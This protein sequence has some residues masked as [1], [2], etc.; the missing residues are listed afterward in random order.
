M[1]T[2]GIWVLTV[3]RETTGGFWLGA[4]AAIRATPLIYLP[5]CF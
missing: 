4:A 1:V 5:T 3:G 2:L